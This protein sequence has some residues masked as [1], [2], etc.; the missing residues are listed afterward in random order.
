MKPT[1]DSVTA[2]NILLDMRD[3]ARLLNCS[4]R[5]VRRLADSR[6]MPR[7]I[8]LGALL[9]WSRPLLMDWVV[10]GCPP[11]EIHEQDRHVA[12]AGKG[13]CDAQ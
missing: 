10:D 2:A 3:V 13:A 8:R 6:R 4:E 12:V 1:P 7:P 9:R 11:V 5:H